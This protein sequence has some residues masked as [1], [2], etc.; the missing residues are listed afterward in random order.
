MTGV[1]KRFF[2][3]ITTCAVFSLL[4]ILTVI[5]GAVPLGVPGEWCWNRT[6]N[7]EFPIFETITV[8]IFSVPRQ[9]L[10]S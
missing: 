1:E 10:L 3:G 2:T 7:I 5:S 8:I 4:L 9:S 6:Q